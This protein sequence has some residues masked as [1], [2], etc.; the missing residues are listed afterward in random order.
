MA[1]VDLVGGGEATV[2]RGRQRRRPEPEKEQGHLGRGCEEAEE[3]QGEDAHQQVVG[4][5][6]DEG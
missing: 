3:R 6:Q 4:F 1:G 5:R 2:D